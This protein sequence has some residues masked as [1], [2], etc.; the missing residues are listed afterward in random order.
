MTMGYTDSPSAISYEYLD[1]IPDK[2]VA[3]NKVNL[4]ALSMYSFYRNAIYDSYK[5][6]PD[7]APDIKAR[8]KEFI[9]KEDSILREGLYKEP[10]YHYSVA[11]SLGAMQEWNDPSEKMHA[12]VAYEERDGKK[13]RI[14][15]VHF[16]AKTVNGKPVVYIAQAGV[17]VRGK[18]TGRHLMECVLT[19]Y[20][21]GTEFYI[22]TRVFNS[23]ARSLYEGRLGF[24]PIKEDEVKLLGYDARYCGFKHTTTPEE[25]SSIRSRQTSMEIPNTLTNEN[26]C[27]I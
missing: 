5:E 3:R 10:L 1:R 23:D 13:H 14:G 15:F 18:G 12:Y 9:E 7:L 25:I 22:L 24:T 20:P 27:Y 26:S 2:K 19:H 21:A 11:A 8:K 16:N 4:S 6:K 17:E